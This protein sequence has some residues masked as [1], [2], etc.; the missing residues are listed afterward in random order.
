MRA[1]H[2]RDLRQRMSVF[3]IGINHVTAPVAIRD[4]MAFPPEVI[5]DALRELSARDSHPE[6]VILSTCNRVEL[7]LSGDISPDDVRHWL[8]EH[9]R[10]SSD[11]LQRCL[12]VKHDAEAIRHIM[13]VASGLD[14][15]VLG[16]PQILGQLKDAFAAAQ[17]AGSLGQQLSR[18]FQQSFAVA[19]QVRTDTAIGQSAVSVAYAAAQLAKRIFADLSKTTVLFIGAGETVQL[20]AQHLVQPGATKVIVANRTVAR[21]E[22]L[23]NLYGGEA[24]PL[25]EL[26]SVLP[27]ADIVISSTASPVPVLGKGLVESAIK[28][29]KHKPIFMVDLAVPRDIEPEVA[30]L[31]DVF[32]YTVDDL[33]TVVQENLKARQDAAVQAETIIAEQVEQFLLWQRERDAAGTI[34]DLRDNWQQIQNQELERAMQRLIAGDAPAEV[35]KQ[36]GHR[37]GNKFLHAPSERLRADAAAGR[38]HSLDTVRHLF[39]LDAAAESGRAENAQTEN[40]SE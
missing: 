27:R 28:K 4:R 36:F 6:A 2:A 33:T 22:E 21:A 1:A 26:A 11:E 30:E 37:L 31:D 15:M 18:L 8:S 14:S 29:R 25:S 3:A 23:A 13:R 39:D 19:K 32:L 7:Y 10:L 20:A 9:R 5:T 34:R 38:S 35:L 40:D 12:Y 24:V 17:S 16:E